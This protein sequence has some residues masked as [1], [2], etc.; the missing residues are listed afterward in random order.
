MCFA[1]KV[2]SI[3]CALIGQYLYMMANLIIEFFICGKL[4]K[5]LMPKKSSFWNIKINWKISS[6]PIIFPC[7]VIKRKITLYLKSYFINMLIE[8]WSKRNCIFIRCG[9]QNTV[10]YCRSYMFASP[11]N[12]CLIIS[13]LK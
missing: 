2:Y 9:Y 7:A 10:S 11:H 1:C 6:F 13:C 3:W 8:M 12:F 4:S 5:N